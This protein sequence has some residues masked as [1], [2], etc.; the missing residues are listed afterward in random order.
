MSEFLEQIETEIQSILSA[1]FS[2]S[3][4][5]IEADTTVDCIFDK[6]YETID[7]ETGAPVMSDTAR[8]SIAID[9]LETDISRT[10]LQGWSC[11]IRETDY[12]I[13]DIQRDGVGMGVLYFDA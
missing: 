4:E 8:A 12:K 13:I 7:P 11:R 3:L 9:K 6:T 5:I 10:V 2:E 1:E